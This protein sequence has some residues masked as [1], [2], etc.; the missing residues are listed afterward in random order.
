MNE[1][2]ESEMKLYLSL[3]LF[4]ILLNISIVL[5]TVVLHEAGHFTV[6][7]YFEC[8]DIK[9]VLYDADTSS[10]YTQMSCSPDT[11][12]LLL[13]LGCFL[14]VVPFAMA[15]LI[16]KD[17]PMRHFAWVILGFNLLIGFGD[18]ELL[19]KTSIIPFI[20]GIIGLFLIV[21]GESLLINKY[22]LL[23]E[24]RL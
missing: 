20:T 13:A 11:P 24:K 1:S 15:F 3:L 10:T 7:N 8:D 18:I 23:I 21:V 12:L 22:L 17:N 5:A 6:G 19:T 9:I 2:A 16:L 14:F 4:V